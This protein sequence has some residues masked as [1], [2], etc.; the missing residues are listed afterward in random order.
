[1]TTSKPLG[2]IIAEA[3]RG[4]HEGWPL[5]RHLRQSPRMRRR[6]RLAM[7][8]ACCD[9]STTVSRT[10]RAFPNGRRNAV[11]NTDVFGSLAARPTV[12]SATWPE[13]D[14]E[15]NQWLATDEGKAATMIDDTTLS[16]WGER[17]RS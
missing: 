11:E 4:D 14:D 12:S 8:S 17:G 7:D 9:K 3:I 16:P 10:V 5:I 13:S 15:L 6:L 1:M 2:Q